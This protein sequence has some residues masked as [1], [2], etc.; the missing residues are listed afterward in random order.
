M[1]GNVLKL[2]SKLKE[3]KTKKTKSKK[4]EEFI[5]QTEKLQK[6]ITEI[7]HFNYMKIDNVSRNL[8]DFRRSI[9]N[10]FQ[11]TYRNNKEDNLYK[12]DINNTGLRNTINSPKKLTLK[13][14]P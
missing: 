11:D 3:F 8:E 6:Q 7:N 13:K 1:E 4:E 5:S 2:A 9:L 14:K 10:L 12:L